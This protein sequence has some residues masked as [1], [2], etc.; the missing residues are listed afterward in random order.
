M[1]PSNTQAAA[2]GSVQQ[3]AVP[4]PAHALSTLSHIEYEDAFLLE[5]GPSRDQTGEQWARAILEG[6]PIVLQRQ[7]RR[8]WLALGLKLG[9]ASSDEFVLGWKI[10]RNTPDYALLGCRSRFG[11][12]AELLFEPQQDKLLFATFV[13]QQNP[14]VRAVWA[15][16]ATHHR[17]VVTYL[18]RR[19]VNREGRALQA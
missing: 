17:R 15:V 6:A 13:Q 4:P 2:L 1:H 11:L 7:L 18:L 16:I 10:V 19:A 9:S 3:I 8:G 5:T 12:P 14:I